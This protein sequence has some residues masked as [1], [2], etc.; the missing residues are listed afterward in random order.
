[1][2]DELQFVAHLITRLPGWHDKLKFAGHY[3]LMI[4]CSFDLTV[5]RSLPM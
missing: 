3:T 2:S 1:M 5:R 4:S